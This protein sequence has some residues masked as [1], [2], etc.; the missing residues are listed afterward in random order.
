MPDEPLDFSAL[1]AAI[2]CLLGIR[3]GVG[4]RVCR[5]VAALTRQRARLWLH[6][7]ERARGARAESPADARLYPVQFA[8]RSYGALVVA[9]EPQDDSKPALLD[10]SA[11][12]LAS[13]CG[14][15]LC[16]LEQAAVLDVLARDLAPKPLEP[17]TPRQRD[18]LAL[19]ARGL[20]DD[21]IM[22]GLHISSGTLRRHRDDL[23][24]RLG[25][26]STRDL[27]LAAYQYGLVLYFVPESG[28]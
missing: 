27:L 7:A 2:E 17:L 13:L 14:V 28:A 15:L 8:G 26:H 22:S 10:A 20:S 18:V 11:R 9:A 6:P 19:I 5:E 1:F 4:D 3:V 12:Q 23:R 25:V 16:L 24:E 21:E